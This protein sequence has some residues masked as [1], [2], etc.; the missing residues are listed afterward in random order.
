MSSAQPVPPK[1]RQRPRGKSSSGAQKP[2][3]SEVKAKLA[4]WR[5]RA[6]PLNPKRKK[7]THW[8][9]GSTEAEEIRT[10]QGLKPSAPASITQVQHSM[11]K[12]LNSLNADALGSRI[13]FCNRQSPNTKLDSFLYYCPKAAKRTFQAQ[14]QHSTILNT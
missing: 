1:S 13:G 9:T 5:S 11:P 8:S 10:P 12:T 3:C 6:G 14:G 4:S 7:E 2:I